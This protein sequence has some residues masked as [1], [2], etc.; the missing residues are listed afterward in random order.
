MVQEPSELHR[1]N[2][3]YGAGTRGRVQSCSF[4]GAVEDRAVAARGQPKTKH[5]DTRALGNTSGGQPYVPLSDG[6]SG[7]RQGTARKDGRSE[8][9]AAFVAQNGRLWT[10]TD[11]TRSKVCIEET[12]SEGPGLPGAPGWGTCFLAAQC[13]CPPES[14]PL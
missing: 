5:N 13:R 12:E 1:Q 3:V 8:V 11:A 7:S 6:Q 14:E 4:Q 10:R 9:G 2:W